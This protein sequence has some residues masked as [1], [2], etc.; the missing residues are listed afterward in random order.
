MKILL[1]IL[2]LLP[3]SLKGQLFYDF[4]AV[5]TEGWIF[6][7][8]GR[9]E[10]SDD[11]PL[12]GERSLHHIYDNIE[13]GVDIAALP[14]DELQASLGDVIWRFT[15][16]H[17]SDPSS[18]NNWGLFLAADA[19][20]DH[21]CPGEEVSGFVAGVN[22]AGYDDTLRI[23]KCDSGVLSPV[24]TT[25]INWQTDIGSEGVASIVITR[26]PEGLWEI[27]VGIDGEDPLHAGSGECYEW[28]DVSLLGICYRYTST[29]DRLLWLDNLSVEGVF[30]TDSYPPVLRDAWFESGVSLVIVTD[31]P[32]S[33]GSLQPANFMMGDPGVHPVEVSAAGTV[34]RL[35]FSGPFENRVSHY[36]VIGSLCDGKGN[37]SGEVDTV[38][39]LSIPEWGDLVITELMPDPDPAVDLPPCE[40][41]EIFNRSDLRFR[42]LQLSLTAGSGV[43]SVTVDRFGPGEYLLITGSNCQW[44][45]TSG[46]RVTDV[47]FQG[48][49]V[50]SGTTVILSDADGNTL[51]GLVYDS[52]WFNDKLKSEGGWSLEMK[53]YDYPFQDRINWSY[54]V[55]PRGGTPGMPN[56]VQSHNPDNVQ[57]W[58]EALYA[59]SDTALSILFS[60]PVNAG[61]TEARDWELVTAITGSPKKNSSRPYNGKK[62][63]GGQKGRITAVSEADRLRREF[64]LSCNPPL[65]PGVLFVLTIPETVSDYG[66][67]TLERNS[68]GTGIASLPDWGDIVVNEILFDPLPGEAEYIEFFNNSNLVVDPAAFFVS[69][70]NEQSGDT[71]KPAWLSLIHR[72]LMPG[73]YFVIT[74]GRESV[75]RCF[76][77]SGRM[78][79][80]ETAVLPSLPDGGGQ[81]LLFT[82]SCTLVDKVRYNALM[83]SDILSGVTGISLEKIYPSAPSLELSSWHS[84]AG[85]SGWGT[86]GIINSV[87]IDNHGSGGEISLSSTRISPDNDG[88]EDILQIT[89][90]T[91][92]TEV[93]ISGTIFSDRG[94]PVRHLAQNLTGS[95]RDIFYWDGKDDSG[96]TV[97]RGLYI[98]FFHLTGIDGKTMHFRKVCAVIR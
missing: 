58:P 68:A 55:S 63:S 4:E 94:L 88:F 40:Y 43:T 32:L 36:L 28:F 35:L 5:T 29:R 46:I 62:K 10:C 60:E 8:P 27:W 7:N 70:L 67:N 51:H 1:F 30:I 19:G 33:S 69:S 75:L 73:D 79:I 66:G 97:S 34:T 87:F 95:G 52:G 26:S 98:L 21:L 80:Y 15:I 24:I 49:L 90:E 39:T 42:H 22:M 74:T 81:L 92:L 47:T 13:S 65:E 31:E 48:T 37:C 16:R 11:Q 57:P 44:D 2:A 41:I 71:G 50:N 3:L 78:A 84:A 82:Q 72:S 54:S 96:L 93:V 56:S 76:P 14:V 20:V 64:I 91:E 59:L 86:P 53:D 61:V 89:V 12:S 9:W 17:G 77:E 83:H 38:I 25:G 45:D 18:S 23:W 6:N 85:T